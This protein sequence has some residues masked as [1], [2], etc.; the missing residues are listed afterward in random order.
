LGV[1]DTETKMVEPNWLKYLFTTAKKW[2]L[3]DAKDLV[4]ATWSYFD[5]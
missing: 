4:Q 5:Y 1:E 2:T 3:Q